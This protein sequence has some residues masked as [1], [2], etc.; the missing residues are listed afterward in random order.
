MGEVGYATWLL[1]FV[2]LEALQAARQKLSRLLQHATLEVMLG[3]H[4]PHL[5]ALRELLDGP[6]ELLLSFL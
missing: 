3:E 6:L 2:L 5:R 4:R 1:T